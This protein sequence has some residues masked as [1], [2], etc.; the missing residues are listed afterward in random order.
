[1]DVL[2]I[3]VKYPRPGSVK[4]RLAASIGKERA[5][6]FYS[7]LVNI[8]VDR[9]KSPEYRRAIFY[10]PGI[11]KRKFKDW[12][13]KRFLYYPQKGSDL[14]ER[15]LNAFKLIFRKGA[16]RIVCIG[17]DS[18]LIDEK[19]ICRAFK[20]LKNRDCVIGPSYDGGYYLIGLSLM[21]GQIFKGISWS[22][23]RVFGQTLDKLKQQKIKYKILLK[24]FDIDT[25]QDLRRLG[26]EM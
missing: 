4:T 25:Y 3:F 26:I 24:S 12:L 18:P 22:T 21:N 9:T 10:S 6:L 5:A 17:T 13:G 19:I 15:L 14:G 23:K 1:M 8:V 2:I 11:P 16:K 7:S 20:A